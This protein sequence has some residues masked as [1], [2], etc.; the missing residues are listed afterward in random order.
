[1]FQELVNKL[2]WSWEKASDEQ[3]KS[4]ANGEAWPELQALAQCKAAQQSVEPTIESSDTAP[5]NSNQ[6]KGDL[7]A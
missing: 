1:M 5:A 7:S 6:S 4:W 2:L 3:I